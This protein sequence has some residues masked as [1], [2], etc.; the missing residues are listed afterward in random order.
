MVNFSAIFIGCRKRKKI[1]DSEA[2]LIQNLT[3]RH[4]KL[5]KLGEF[6]LVIGDIFTQ[7]YLLLG[8]YKEKQNLTDENRYTFLR[9]I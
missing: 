1:S 9:I 6:P 8:K 3:Q 5:E 4:K 7:F 2:G